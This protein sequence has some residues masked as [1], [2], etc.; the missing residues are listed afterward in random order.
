MGD[1]TREKLLKK[2][3]E[4]KLQVKID[5]ISTSFFAEIA[6]AAGTICVEHEDVRAV[7]NVIRYYLTQ[8]K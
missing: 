8:N 7:Q 2:I 4:Q 5:D 6:D 1:T 3:R